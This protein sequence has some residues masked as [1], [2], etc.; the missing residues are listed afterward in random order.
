MSGFFLSVVLRGLFDMASN[1]AFS[2]IAKYSSRNLFTCRIEARRT[3]TC[4]LHLARH[5]E[6]HLARHAELHHG[7]LH[8]AKHEDSIEQNMRPLSSKT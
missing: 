4:R 8:R 6:L 1:I 2:K 7:G 5:A 3:P